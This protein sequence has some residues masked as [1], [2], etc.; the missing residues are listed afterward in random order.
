MIDLLCIAMKCTWTSAQATRFLR[1]AGIG[2]S[3][4]TRFVL[5][6]HAS[7]LRVTS[8]TAGVCQKRVTTGRPQAGR[9]L[10]WTSFLLAARR[11]DRV[12]RRRAGYVWRLHTVVHDRVGTWSGRCSVLRGCAGRRP[13]EFRFGGTDDG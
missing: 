3:S 4:E 10:S 13:H 12:S 11:L 9:R 2:R 8:D 6:A 7:T 5:K 1:A